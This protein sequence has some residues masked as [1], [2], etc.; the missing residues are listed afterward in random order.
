M[1]LY[2]S[3]AHRSAKGVPRK[4]PSRSPEN[5]PGLEWLKAWDHARGLRASDHVPRG[6]GAWS[7][8]FS[9]RCFLVTRSPG[10]T[11]GDPGATPGYPGDPGATPG[12]FEVVRRYLRNGGRIRGR[13]RKI[14]I[15]GHFKPFQALG[16]IAFCS[17]RNFT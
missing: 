6:G 15:S 12:R 8:G 10:V 17:P 16:P 14:V 3:D 2:G 9:L 4:W 11:P 13:I 1:A 7:E 5:P